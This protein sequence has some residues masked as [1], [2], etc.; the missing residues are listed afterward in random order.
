M[1]GNGMKKGIALALCAVGLATFGLSAASDPREEKEVIATL[2][3]LIQTFSTKDVAMAARIYHE[4][5]SFGHNAGDLQTKTAA[6]KDV[7]T[8]RWQ[9]AKMTDATVT[10]TGS[11]AIVRT[12]MNYQ[13][14]CST[15]AGACDVRVLWVLT[16]GPGPN[17][18]QVIG[19]QATWSFGQLS[20]KKQ[21]TKPLM[22]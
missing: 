16:K 17:G 8:G 14:D 4:N 20:V 11:V 9:A 12:I 19:R 10:V 15:P 3:A 18:W 5:L 2:D 7:E 13:K 6:L 22:K 21:G 1:K